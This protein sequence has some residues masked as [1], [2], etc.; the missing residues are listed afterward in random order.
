MPIVL[1]LVFICFYTLTS[2]VLNLVSG[3]W[4]SGF[5]RLILSY[6]K[7]CEETDVCIGREDGT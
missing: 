6:G 3:N 2:H 4:S 7:S 5:K 1:C